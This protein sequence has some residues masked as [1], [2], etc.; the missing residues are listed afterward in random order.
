MPPISTKPFPENRARSHRTSSS[1]KFERWVSGFYLSILPSEF[2]DKPHHWVIKVVNNA[3]LQWND[4]V[5]GNVDLFRAD[6]CTALGDVTETDPEV[7]FKQLGARQ[8]VERVHL[9]RRYA[10]EEAWA[11]ELFLLLMVA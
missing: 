7:I 6:L 1:I 3:L 2:T 9:E 10:N 11:T 8:P 5:V 4:R